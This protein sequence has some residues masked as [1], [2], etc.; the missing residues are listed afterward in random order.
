MV[1]RRQSNFSDEKSFS[2]IEDGRLPSFSIGPCYLITRQKRSASLDSTLNKNDDLIPAKEAGINGDAHVDNQNMMSRY[3]Y[4]DLD[5]SNGSS[6]FDL[7]HQ[8]CAVDITVQK[9]SLQKRFTKR[10]SHK[11]K[12]SKNLSRKEVQ[13]SSKI[14]SKHNTLVKYK[15]NK[16]TSL[17]PSFLHFLILH[18]KCK[19]IQ[20][21]L[22]FNS[23]C[24][25]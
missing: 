4:I 3:D 6:E 2:A 19:D 15:S 20:G 24:F 8:D 25:I 9:L 12:N 1:N 21:F 14:C 5:I 22:G 16:G 18:M 17:L 13:K 23:F 10:G 7:N 11:Y